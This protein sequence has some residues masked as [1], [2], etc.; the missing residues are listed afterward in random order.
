MQYV[1]TIVEQSYSCVRSHLVYSGTILNRKET[2]I[3]YICKLYECG[4]LSEHAL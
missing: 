4:A 1:D 3:S 2:K